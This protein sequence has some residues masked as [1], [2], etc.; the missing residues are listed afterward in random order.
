MHPVS[1]LRATWLMAGLETPALVRAALALA[2]ALAVAV[3]L[4]GQEPP[5]A[6][7][8]IRR[9]E[10][11]ISPV[12]DSLEAQRFWGYRLLNAFHAE[13]KPY[14][15]RR[16]LL[17]AP[18]EAYDTARVHESERNL[19]A[20][21]IFR[22]VRIDTVTTDSGLAVRVRTTDGWTTNVGFGIQ[23]SGSQVLVNAFV[24]EVNLFGTRTIATLGY[25]SDPDRSSVLVGFDTP[26]L[27]AAKIGAGALYSRR[28][29]GHFG[30][31][32][33]RYPFFSLS[34]R[35]G[36]S[37]TWQILDGRELH[38]AEG[39]RA[40][41]DS[42]RKKFALL[43]ADGALALAASTRGYTRV[44]IDAQV[45]R[46]DYGPE[47]PSVEL[48]RTITVAAGPFVAFRRPRYIQMRNYESMGRIEDVDLGPSI[49]LG[50]SAAPG[51]W[52]YARDGV[53]GRAGA[54]MGARIPAG[55]VQVQA[56]ASGV[57]SGGPDSSTV[58]AA[59]LSVVQPD[60]RHLVVGFAAAGRRENQ[61]FGVE[62]DLGLGYALRAFPAHAF[63]GDRQYLLNAEYRWLVLPRV[64]GLV[65]LGVAAFMDHGGAWFEGSGRRTGT[66]A[67]LGLRI[68]SIRSAASLIG[69]LDLAYR[70]AN[71]REPAGWV[72][73]LGRGFAFQRF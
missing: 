33:V 6:G 44:G 16:E 52:G 50:V 21:S 8:M 28:S 13:T 41:M 31:A 20:L 27:I 71:D 1:N 53:G 46:E 22:E 37:L 57:H 9:V 11:H 49:R 64:L 69:R 42:A 24:Q 40:P 61:P 54:V 47:R 3:P 45:R 26:R 68:G 51:V 10:V 7:P 14:I 38:Y 18:G 19:R 17:F 65:G 56:L 15:I 62:Y 67:G 23:T 73:S 32:S 4:H 35:G 39:R 60:D 34:S 58:E 59:L 5:P 63:T 29:D 30:S 43:R 36:W 66:D 70:F 12:F 25:Q 2:L 48:P 55:F 72:V